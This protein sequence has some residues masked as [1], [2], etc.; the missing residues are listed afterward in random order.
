[1]KILRTTLALLLCAAVLLP[2]GAFAA[3]AVSE[4]GTGHEYLTLEGENN[5]GLTNYRFVDENGNEVTPVKGQNRPLLRAINYPEKYD[6]RDRGLVT[7][8]KNQSPFGT[9]WA[10]SFCAA[11]ETS[12]IKQGFETADSVD[13][14]EAHLAY[15]SSH[16][17]DGEIHKE[18][19][20]DGINDENGFSEG[21]S[22]QLAA[23]AAARWSGLAKE[24]DYPYINDSEKMFPPYRTWSYSDKYVSDY[25]IVSCRTEQYLN[26]IQDVKRAITESG[27]AALCF[28][29]AEECCLGGEGSPYSYCCNQPVLPNHAVLAVGW[30][31]SF[32]NDLFADDP[33]RK[34]AWLCKNSWGTEWGDEGYFWLSYYDMTIS[35]YTELTAV[36]AGSYVN[37]YQYDGFMPTGLMTSYGSGTAYMANIFTAE[38]NEYVSGAGFTTLVGV[39]YNVYVS[40]YTDLEKA[41]DPMSGTLRETVPLRLDG[42]GYYTVDF[43]GEYELDEWEKF[44]VVVTLDSNSDA[45]YIT[46][47]GREDSR[48]HYA[49]NENESFISYDG[50]NWLESPLNN[51][52]VKA[53]TTAVRR[54]ESIEINTLPKKEVFY[55]GNSFDTSGLSLK[56]TFEDGTTE[57]IS[58]G[59]TWTADSFE[60]AGDKTVYIRYG[61]AEISL[62]TEVREMPESIVRGISVSDMK[63]DYKDASNVPVKIDAPSGTEYYVTYASSHPRVAYVDSEGCIYGL[64]RGTSKVT[65]TVTDIYGNSYTDSCTVKVRWNFWQW[66]IIIFLFGWLWYI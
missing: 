66:L 16:S 29:F 35:E 48:T 8:V 17:Y 21:G 34:G 27:S 25:Q 9:C 38:G 22:I 61:G 12:L 54:V 65:C 40:L 23:S 36:P 20:R 24:A 58:K 18:A 52:P 32:S 41:D 1:M 11:A 33:G 37:N 7:P 55:T 4:N 30:D 49:S 39:G 46:M 42:A 64:S 59:Y 15:Y 51:V 31:D 6:A 19:D 3:G 50:E 26:S 10:F 2:G 53:F 47:E 5:G 43:N 14:S 28:A 62:N 57:I 45:V 13:L 56:V 60:T 44:S 63:L